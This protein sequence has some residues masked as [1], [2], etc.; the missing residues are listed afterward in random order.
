MYVPLRDIPALL[1][2]QIN[3]ENIGYKWEKI[4]K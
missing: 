4:D 3:V 2:A 1:L